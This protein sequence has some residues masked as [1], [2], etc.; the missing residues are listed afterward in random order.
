MTSP[1]LNMLGFIQSQLFSFLNSSGRV[2]HLNEYKL[3]STSIAKHGN[4]ND[5]Q[6]QSWIRSQRT[7][8]LHC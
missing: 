1:P 6:R 7:I 2:I 3:A 5:F 4:P 8:F